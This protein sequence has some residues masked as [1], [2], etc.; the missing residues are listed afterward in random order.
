MSE[1]KD[2]KDLVKLAEVNGFTVTST[3]GGAHNRG[4]K[5]YLKLAI[6]VRTR[7]KTTAECDEFIKRCRHLGLIVHD[8]RRKP[9]HQKVWS[10]PHLHI[11]IESNKTVH[12][13][14]SIEFGDKGVPVK[15]VQNKLVKLGF[16]EPKD[17]D[18]DFGEITRKAVLAFQIKAGLTEDGK[19]GANTQKELSKS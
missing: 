15:D 18:G 8:E 19:V 5:H 4:S 14:T 6:D 2:Y 17:V 1:F 9:L 3:T 13:K 12:A 16:L 11:H 7:D 10:G